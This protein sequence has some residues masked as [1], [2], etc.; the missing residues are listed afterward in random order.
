MGNI[1]AKTAEHNRSRHIVAQNEWQIVGNCLNGWHRLNC[2]C[3][4]AG[5]V[6]VNR[7]GINLHGPIRIWAAA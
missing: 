4:G 1:Q 5:R 3:I 2:P 6:E 7:L